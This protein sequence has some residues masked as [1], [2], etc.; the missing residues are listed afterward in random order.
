ML[1]G[2]NRAEMIHTVA[3][4]ISQERRAHPLRVGIDGVD[5]AGKTILADELARAI[6]RPVIRASID[7]FHHPRTVR[8][9][10]GSLSPEGYYYDSFNNQQVIDVLLAPLGPSGTAEYRTAIFD[11]RTDSEVDIP[12]RKAGRDDILLMDGVFLFRPELREY[13][14]VK[15]FVD[16]PF[17]VTVP[18]AVHRDGGNEETRK[19]YQ[20]RYLPGQQLYLEEAQPKKYADIIINKADIEHP[21]M[22]VH[23]DTSA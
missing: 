7:G 20:L 9:Q 1:R 4:I 15:L 8:Y 6:K 12:T 11:Y 5:G 2:V 13:W 22:W 19:Q 3:A 16:A 21:S 14:D 23:M 10:R 18:R 17:S